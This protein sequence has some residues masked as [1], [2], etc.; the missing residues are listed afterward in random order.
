MIPVDQQKFLANPVIQTLLPLHVWTVNNRD[1]QKF[2]H[3]G[4]NLKVPLDP[5]L[6][7]NEN[8]IVGFASKKRHSQHATYYELQNLEYVK[9]LSCDVLKTHVLAVDL[10]A[11]TIENQNQ[12]D[13]CSEVFE[14]VQHDC[15]ANYVEQSAHG[16]EHRLL[17]IPDQL[18][19][20]PRYQPLFHANVIKLPQKTL[21]VFPSGLHHMTLTQR[22]VDYPVVDINHPD[23]VKRVASFLDWLLPYV[24]VKHDH[25]ISLNQIENDDPFVKQFV[26]Y[27]E[28]QMNFTQLAQKY[29]DR[30]DDRS[31]Y[32]Y[33]LCCS[34]WGKVDRIY[35]ELAQNSMRDVIF[36]NFV[37]QPTITQ[38]ASVVYQCMLDYFDE[39][40]LYREKL[41]EQRNDTN[42]LMFIIQQAYCS[43]K[44]LVYRK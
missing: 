21:E 16:G 11:K 6:L 7:L 38:M 40:D 33:S 42:Y 22:V 43:L 35:Q 37:D 32:D 18:L 24:H 2:K 25:E 12:D 28:N 1:P 20:D 23:Y 27:A 26:K 41:S 4:D 10:E 15:Y 9:V 13:W 14:H 8:Q 31:R 29:A 19:N 17:Q 5:Y 34:M 36:P 39:N 3:S 30:L 44:G